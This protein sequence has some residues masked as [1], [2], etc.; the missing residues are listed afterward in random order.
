MKTRAFNGPTRLALVGVFAVVVTGCGTTQA[1]KSLAET[2]IDA[3]NLSC[4]QFKA[5]YAKLDKASEDN[6][7]DNTPGGARYSMR[8]ISLFEV[9]GYMIKNKQINDQ[10][11][12]KRKLLDASYSSKKCGHDSATVAQNTSAAAAVVTR[13][14]SQNIKQVASTERM[15]MM[16]MQKKLV[17]SGYL[18]GKPDGVF[19]KNTSDALKKFQEKNGLPITGKPDNETIAIL[20]S[21]QFK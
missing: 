11:A 9:P 8:A 3:N 18:R 2:E 1:D 21:A 7:A 4:A 19:G 10:I 5:A 20:S 13:D 15:S 14:A 17:D 12:E 6:I 16:D